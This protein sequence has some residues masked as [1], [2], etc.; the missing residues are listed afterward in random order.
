MGVQRLILIQ[1]SSSSNHESVESVEEEELEDDDMKDVSTTDATTDATTNATTEADAV[2]FGAKADD[3]QHCI[4][5]PLSFPERLRVS[6]PQ[7][8]TF[9][10]SL[11][12]TVCYA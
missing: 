5:D 2:P 6:Q 7:D 4:E 8:N 10:V 12:F 1:P 3:V 9:Q 11:S